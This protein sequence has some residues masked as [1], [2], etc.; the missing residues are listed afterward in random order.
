MTSQNN[1]F[2]IPPSSA[3]AQ[4]T[5]GKKTKWYS[6][7]WAKLLLALLFLVLVMSVAMAFYI[8]RTA[9][10]LKTGQLTAQDL[11]GAGSVTNS[12]N[13]Q[14]YATADDPAFGAPDAKVVI[15]EFSDFQCPFCKQVQPVVKKILADY[16][17]KVWFV[18]RDFP[19]ESLHPQAVMAALAAE[20]AHEQGKFWDMHDKIFENQDQLSSANLKI[21]ALQIG[22]N[23][24]QFGN[25]LDSAQYFDAVN[26]DLQDGI[27]AGVKATPTFFINGQ[28]V[29]GAIPLAVFEQI[30]LS[31]LSQ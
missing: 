18:Y 21:W 24:I 27:A 28:K 23:S 30:I 12:A 1:D 8:T 7:W 10:L 14:T 22:L 11:F 26:Q 5:V 19:L 17:N 6:K 20:C 31:E 25:C 15:V 3:P 29:E 13:V 4:F 2:Y 9:Y 16:G